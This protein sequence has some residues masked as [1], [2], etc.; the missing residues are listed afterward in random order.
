MKVHSV[1]G[2]YGSLEA[3]Q[4]LG[5]LAV[6]QR[7]LVADGPGLVFFALLGPGV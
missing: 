2:G 6:L 4:A 7:A 5:A 3:L 1:D